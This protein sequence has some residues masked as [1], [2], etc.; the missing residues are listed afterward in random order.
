MINNEG[1]TA[2]DFLAFERNFLTQCRF[3]LLL[4][5]LSS[6]FL[7]RARI[8]SPDTTQNSSTSESARLP[9]GYIYFGFGFGGICLALW[10]YA[11][12]NKRLRA[13]YA[14]LGVT[15]YVCRHKLNQT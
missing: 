10:Y 8:P 15:K 14:F 1:S 9:F 11:L 3:G 13:K 6:S 4:S 5:L 2:R 7:L 12:S